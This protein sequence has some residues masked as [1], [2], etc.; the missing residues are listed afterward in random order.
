MTSAGS[1]FRSNPFLAL[2]WLF[3]RNLVS[4]GKVFL[5][6]GV[7]V[8]SCLLGF[9]LRQSSN[10]ADVMDFLFFY[11]LAL[12]V[13]VFSLVMASSALGNLVEDETLVYLWLRPTRRIYIAAAA[14]LASFA[15]SLPPTVIP[16]TLAT[17]IATSGDSTLTMATFGAVTLGVLAYT[18]LFTLL[19]LLLRR[20]LI[21]GL[22]YLFIWELFVTKAGE[23]AA[24]LSVSAYPLAALVEWSQS[25]VIGV[26]GGALGDRSL[27]TAVL[28]PFLVAV[29]CIGLTGYRLAKSNVT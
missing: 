28:V 14:W 26:E 7:G 10:P 17:A 23:G 3:S 11:G 8:L 15:L 9:A 16:L 19:G 25:P 29:V 2:V 5:A 1:V 4:K 20:A 18:A 6:L 27:T 13:P 12:V 24:S 22:A 21:I